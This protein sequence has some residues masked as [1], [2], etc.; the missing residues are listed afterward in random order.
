MGRVVV[1]EFVTLDGVI[2]APGGGEEFEHAGWSFRFDRGSEGDQFK[3][4]ELQAAGALLLG[5]VTYEAFARVWPTFSDDQGFADRFNSMP[6]FVASTT[7]ERGDWGPTTVIR[8]NLGEEVAKARAFTDGDVLVNGSAQLVQGLVAEDLVDEY[9]LML[10][11]TVLGSGKRL[12]G[13]GALVP[14]LRLVE[15]RPLGP[16]GIVLLT[17]EPM[18]N[19]AS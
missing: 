4:E 9:R 11:P 2:E 10:F 17:Y 8:D 16:D 12:F 19:G 7:L 3:L 15:S 13:E 18:R 6:K 5:R 1:S 14:T